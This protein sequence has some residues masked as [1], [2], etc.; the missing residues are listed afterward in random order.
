MTGH[1]GA[2]GRDPLAETSGSHR[3]PGDPR[4]RR[5]EDG[6]RERVLSGDDRGLVAALRR[7]IVVTGLHRVAHAIG[8]V[9][10]GLPPDLELVE[11]LSCDLAIPKTLK[12]VVT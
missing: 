5:I 7:E 6:V 4:V 10:F 11:I 1:A 8:G 12:Q 9:R 3:K 2:T